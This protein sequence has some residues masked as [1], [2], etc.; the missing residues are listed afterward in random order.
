MSCT[1]LWLS[2]VLACIVF[3]T[4]RAASKISYSDILYTSLPSL[5]DGLVCV[6]HVYNHSATGNCLLQVY[7]IVY[8]KFSCYLSLSFLF[9]GVNN[10]CFSPH[11]HLLSQ[12]PKIPVL[13]VAMV[14]DPS[15]DS[16]VTEEGRRL[17]KQH[18]AYFLASNSQEWGSKSSMYL[19]VM[20][21]PSLQLLRPS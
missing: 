2:T 21:E 6:V 20:V 4:Y 12:L 16:H 13:I 15:C 1:T 19:S 11:R 3:T 9:C 5:A 10:C 17:A 8:C 18:G 7:N 14:T